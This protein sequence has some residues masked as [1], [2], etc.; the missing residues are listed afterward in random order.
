MQTF[1]ISKVQE[2]SYY[3]IRIF[4]IVHLVAAVGLVVLLDG[5]GNGL[6]GISW[7]LVLA[8]LFFS[9]FLLLRVIQA[10][11]GRIHGHYVLTRNTLALVLPGQPRV[12]VHRNECTGVLPGY[13]K[14]VLRSGQHLPLASVSSKPYLKDLVSGVCKIWWPGFYDTP[15]WAGLLDSNRVGS[16]DFRVDFRNKPDGR[17]PLLVYTAGT[18]HFVWQYLGLAAC[19]ILSFF[20]AVRSYQNGRKVLSDQFSTEQLLHGIAAASSLLGTVAALGAMI[21]IARQLYVWRSANLAFVLSRRTIALVRAGK[22]TVY[23][24]ADAWQSFNEL[25]GRLYFLGGSSLI[26]APY[27]L[28]TPYDGMLR[29]LFLRWRP[30]HTAMNTQIGNYRG[31]N[32]LFILMM[33]LWVCIMMGEGSMFWCIVL[34]YLSSSYWTRAFER[35]DVSVRRTQDSPPGGAVVASR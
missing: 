24:R 20:F 28:G 5:P 7:T 31:N 34:L 22:P 2:R 3:A 27:L 19:P 29:M 26:A 14:L 21:Y 30:D 35:A 11:A 12:F 25:T 15:L 10:K 32:L 1:R 33:W 9:A 16:L 23:Q 6:R 4:G 17:D 18:S 8:F 13:W